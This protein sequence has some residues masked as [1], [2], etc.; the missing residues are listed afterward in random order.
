[1]TFTLRDYQEDALSRLRASLARHHR[2]LLVMPT[3]SGKSALA[4]YMGRRA[5]DKGN[6]TWF[7]AHRSEL[8]DQLSGSLW[9]QGVEHGRIQGGHAPSVLPI[10]VASIQTIARRLVSL[11]PRPPDL[12]VVDEAHRTAA[13]SYRKLLDAY[14][15]ARVVGLTATPRRTDGKGLGELYEDLVL[16]PTMPWLMERGY[17]CDYRIFGAEQQID[18]SSVRTRAGDYVREQAEEAVDKPAITGNCVQEYLRHARGKRAVV[19][20]VGRSHA[21]HVRDAFREA[22]VPADEVDGETKTDDRKAAIRRFR[23][24]ESHVLTSVDLLIEGLD[25]P[26]IEVVIILRPTKS[27]IVHLQMLGRGLRPAAGKDHLLILDHVGNA[28]RPELGLPDDEREWTLAGRTKKRRNTEI[29]T[30]PIVQCPRCYRVLRSGSPCPDATPDCP[31]QVSRGRQIE[32]R[33]GQLVEMNKEAFR[34][35][36]RREEREARTL[37]DFQRIGRERNYHPGWAY[38]KWKYSWQRKAAQA[39]DRKEARG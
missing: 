35:Q 31:L 25:I 7:I 8:L 34:R 16:G 15:H 5:A 26:G 6:R 33:E 20:C 39:A 13:P 27:V 37:E 36:R 4:A 32:E 21:K 1:M 30:I 17:L 18:L 3:G 28:L 12:I 14:P 2:S 24:G 23:S 22:G 38:M 11:S 29:P 19:F 9:E 10:Q